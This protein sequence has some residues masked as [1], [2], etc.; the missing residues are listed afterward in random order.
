MSNPKK[1]FLNRGFT[2][3]ELLMVITIIVIL[4]TVIAVNFSDMRKKDR[5]TRAKVDIRQIVN[6]FELKYNELQHYPP[7]PPTF[8]PCATG[9][10]GEPIPAG[11]TSLDPYLN[12]IPQ[13]NGARQYFWYDDGSSQPQKFCLYFQLELDPSEYFTCSNM[14]CQISNSTTCLGF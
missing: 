8:A 5:D 2:L 12:P 4:I 13:G 7:T 10:C 1:P 6:A 14:G 11:D 3:I 9:L